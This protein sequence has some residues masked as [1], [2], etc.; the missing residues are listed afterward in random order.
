MKEEILKLR[1]EGKSYND[2]S[3]ILRCS[4]STI[5]YHCGDGQK[6][7]TDE[8]RRKRRKN[9]LLT[10]TERFIYRKNKNIN[11]TIRKFQKRDNSVK[12][13]VDSN[14]E[15]TFSWKDVIQKFGEDTYCYLSGE[16]IN[17]YKDNYNLDHIIPSSRGG[18][19]SLDNLGITHKIVNTMKSDLTPEELIEWCKKILE[20]NN[21]KVEKKMTNEKFI[22][23]MTC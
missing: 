17:L 14:I 18:D 23:N 13:S 8:R 5:S 7:K 12:G 3:K 22:K 16:K 15:T 11:E 21:Y 19:N 10:K 9:I 2:I 20:F 4:K 1:K 6:E